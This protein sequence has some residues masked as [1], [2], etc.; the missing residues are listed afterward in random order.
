MSGRKP[1]SSMRSASSSTRHLERGELG[2][3]EPEVVEQA[4]RGRDD[5]VD[6]ASE[7]VLLRSHADAADDGGAR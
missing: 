7:G 4:A 6:A 5:H 1:M 2:V 3:G